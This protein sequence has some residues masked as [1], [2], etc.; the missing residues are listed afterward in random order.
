MT[1]KYTKVKV[2]ADEYND[3][4][5]LIE[6]S[7]KRMMVA[8]NK[9]VKELE[10]A[11]NKARKDLAGMKKAGAGLTEVSTLMGLIKNQS[12]KVDRHTSLINEKVSEIMGKF[13]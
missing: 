7:S 13:S 8:L 9:S 2:K 6:N 10:Q 3:A 4:E 5:N 12:E 1:L 11:F